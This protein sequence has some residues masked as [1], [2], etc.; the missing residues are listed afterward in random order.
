MRELFSEVEL[1]RETA[2]FIA[3]GLR[4][5]AAVDGVHQAELALIQEFERGV[6]V[7]SIPF[8]LTGDHPL[9][10]AQTRELF[11]RSAILLSMADGEISELEGL[12]LGRYSNQLGIGVERLAELYRDVKVF[13]L[14]A[15][16]GADLFRDEAERIGQEMGLEDDDIQTTLN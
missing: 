10:T 14:S 9:K 5:L 3:A 1:D 16:E 12:R 6:G 8:D 11:M 4:E 2:S 15:F 7:V 13:L